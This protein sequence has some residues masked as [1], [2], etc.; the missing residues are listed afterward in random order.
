[1]TITLKEI[2]ELEKKYFEKLKQIL[3]QNIKEL[4]QGFNS[5]E[6]IKRDYANLGYKEN[7]VEKGAERVLQSII[8]KNT[9]WNVNSAPISSDLLFE[10]K[11]AMINIDA[12]TYKE[13][14]QEPNKINVGANQI[15][16]GRHLPMI[17][18]RTNTK[19]T[20]KAALR[21]IY[22]HQAHGEIPCLTFFVKFV[23]DDNTKLLKKAELVNVPNGELENIY[24]K[25]F[26]R[27]KSE[28]VAGKPVR[29]IRVVISTF[30]N[31]KLIQDWKR[32]E[33]IYPLL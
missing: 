18:N 24:K 22:R 4:E 20:W 23:Y 10:T 27:G 17:S 26:T 15:S 31:P 13:K 19:Y 12:K 21:T 9:G 7:D 25:I 1:M 33:Q 11:E 6:N 5:K 3:I 29:D 14:H 2:E 30:E 16:Y 28:I 8:S 32:K